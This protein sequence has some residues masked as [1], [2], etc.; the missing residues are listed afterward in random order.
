MMKEIN[1]E[2]CLK[3]LKESHES[4]NNKKDSKKIQVITDKMYFDPNLYKLR[5]FN[6]E[7]NQKNESLRI[8]KEEINNQLINNQVI[9]NKSTIA[10]F[11]K[12]K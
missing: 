12:K 6:K 9:E 5:K 3:I 11:F 10:N 2:K 4:E 1:I 8:E 7:L